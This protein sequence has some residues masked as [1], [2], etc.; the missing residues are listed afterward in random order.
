MAGKNGIDVSRYTNKEELTFD[1]E[2]I[3]P[4]FLGGADGN[5]EIR[6]APFK[7]LLRRWWRIVNGNLSPEELW[8][9]E[10]ELFGS[11]E[12]DM[13]SG[14]IFGKSKVV[15][16][17][18][19]IQQ[20]DYLSSENINIGEDDYTDLALYTGYG[21]VNMGK[22][23]IVPKTRCSFSISCPKENEHEI[24]KT[25]F[26]VHLFGTIGSRSRNGWGSIAILP[27]SFKFDPAKCFPQALILEKVWSSNKNYPFCIGKDEKGMLCWQTAER[28]SSWKSAFEDIAQIYHQLVKNLNEDDKNFNTKWRKLLGFAA[29]NSRLS[30]QLLLKVCITKTKI[31]TGYYGMIVHVPYLVSDWKERDGDQKKA[32]QFIHEWLDSDKK[33]IGSMG[34]KITGLAK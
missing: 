11:T 23:Y 27:K 28:Y 5:A 15:L 13:A 10:S 25:L 8:K 34:R 4:A 1:V 26:Y 7:S 20:E 21:S 14:K 18:I 6:T 12:K 17:I 19:N 30:S 32:W 3:T 31:Q 22:K 9:K 33:L 29:G 2:F 24:Q 16:K